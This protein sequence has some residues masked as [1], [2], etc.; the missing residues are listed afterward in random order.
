[1]KKLAESYFWYI[2]D[3]IQLITKWENYNISFSTIIHFSCFIYVQFRLIWNICIF[4][5]LEK[6]LSQETKRCMIAFFIHIVSKA[7]KKRNTEKYIL[8]V[9]FVENVSVSELS[10]CYW[11]IVVTMCYI[12]F[13][14]INCQV[15]N[16]VF[17][18]LRILKL[19]TSLL[20]NWHCFNFVLSLC[21]ILHRIHHLLYHGTLGNFYRITMYIVFILLNK[22]YVS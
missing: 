7:P 16:K 9:T 12:R 6:A 4:S 10:N 21:L 14:R 20:S 1:M 18:V 5:F 3:P 8:P 13:I 15:T 11:A 2:L 22:A 17:N 19:T